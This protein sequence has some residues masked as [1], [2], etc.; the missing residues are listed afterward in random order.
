MRQMLGTVGR[1]HVF[2]LIRSLALGDGPNA[3]GHHWQP[4]QTGPERHLTLEDDPHSCNAAVAQLAH[5]GLG[6]QTPKP[7]V[8][9]LADLAPVRPSCHTACACVAR[10]N[11]AGPDDILAHRPMVLLPAGVSARQP[12]RH[13]AQSSPAEKPQADQPTA[14]AGPQPS[15]PRAGGGCGSSRHLRHQPVG[16]SSSISAAISRPPVVTPRQLCGHLASCRQ[17]RQCSRSP[18]PAAPVIVAHIVYRG[19]RVM[20][21]ARADFWRGGDGHGAGRTVGAL[22]RSC[23]PS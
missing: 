7:R 20:S 4:A 10:R 8:Q 1:Q 3:V 11:W 9:R 13:P 15:P 17:C 2:A 16:L 12:V 14:G 18:G 5:T 19:R 22:V 23:N 6:Q 21:P